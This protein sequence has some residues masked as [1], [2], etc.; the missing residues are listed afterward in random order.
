[1]KKFQ[2]KLE[3]QELYQSIEPRIVYPRLKLKL[4]A[5]LV[6]RQPEPG[7]PEPSPTPTASSRASTT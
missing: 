6:G 1:L 3:V 7:T 2:L 5:K 4:V